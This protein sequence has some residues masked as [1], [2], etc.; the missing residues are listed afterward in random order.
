[1]ERGQPEVSQGQP[2]PENQLLAPKTNGIFAHIAICPWALDSSS[3]FFSHSQLD[4]P[5]HGKHRLFPVL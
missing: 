2:I 4:N 5:K 3:Q 1:V